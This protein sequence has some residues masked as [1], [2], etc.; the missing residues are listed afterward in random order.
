LTI[1]YPERFAQA[2]PAG[3]DGVWDWDFLRGAF[4]PVIMP[5]DLDGMVERNGRFLVF[6]TKAAGVDIPQGQ[7]ITLDALRATGV[8]TIFILYGKTAATLSGF[9]EWHSKKTMRHPLP[10]SAETVWLRA[11][12]WFVYVNSLPALTQEQLQQAALDSHAVSLAMAEYRALH[13]QLTNAHRRMA[14]LERQ[15]ADERSGK[16]KRLAKKC[17]NLNLE[18]DL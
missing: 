5:M 17:G 15:L 7:R 14:I 8:F 13:E 11:H 1:L 12:Q 3:F 9:E 6:E 16:T 10:I 18:L 4:G 2:K